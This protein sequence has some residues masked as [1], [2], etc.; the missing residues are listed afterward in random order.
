MKYT[1]T[2]SCGFHS[3][4]LYN[5]IQGSWHFTTV[6]TQDTFFAMAPRRRAHRFLTDLTGPKS[7]GLRVEH[8]SDMVTLSYWQVT[9]HERF[10]PRTTGSTICSENE[11]TWHWSLQTLIGFESLSGLSQRGIKGSECKLSTFTTSF[12]IL[13]SKKWSHK[14][15]PQTIF[16]HVHLSFLNRLWLSKSD[17]TW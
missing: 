10:E 17:P 15:S 5:E 2:A 3:C 16:Y 8:G 4:D 1:T 14:P 13:L 6:M 11:R 9:W 7:F 12:A